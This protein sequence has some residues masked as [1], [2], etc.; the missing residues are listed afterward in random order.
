MCFL[1]FDIHQNITAYH[2]PGNVPLGDILNTSGSHNLTI[3]QD[4]DSVAYFLN[5]VE[6]MGDKN[7]G[8]ALLFQIFQLNEKFLCFLGCEH[9]GGLVQQQDLCSTQQNFQNLHSLLIAYGQVHDP[10]V[11]VDGKIVLFGNLFGHPDCL[12]IIK[13]YPF[14]PGFRAQNHVFCYRERRDKH[15]MLM[16]HA[17]AVLQRNQG[18]GYLHF[19][20]VNENFAF[21]R[22]LLSEEHLHQGGFPRSVFSHEAM[23]FSFLNTKSDILIGHETVGV[24]FGNVLHG[25]DFRRSRCRSRHFHSSLCLYIRKS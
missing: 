15:K 5:L 7:Y 11:R 19:L 3:P 24:N 17:D 9:G 6:L 4:G 13:E 20:P 22:H 14:L 12:L 16:N 1:F 8:K 23:D 21:F 10:F 2:H 18:I 25:K